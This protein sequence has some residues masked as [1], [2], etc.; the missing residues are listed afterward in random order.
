MKS[1][2]H[3]GG[4]LNV[5]N[6]VYYSDT[7]P[8]YKVAKPNAYGGV[9]AWCAVTWNGLIGP[10]FPEGKINAEVY[11][12]MLENEF[13]PELRK[14]VDPRSTWFQQ[15]GARA[16]TAQTTQQYLNGVFG[17][18]W[19]GK[20]SDHVWPAGSPDLTV[21]DYWLWNRLL[22]DTNQTP[23]RTKEQMKSAIEKACRGV[24][25]QECQDA[26]SGF[27]RRL[28]ECVEKRGEQVRKD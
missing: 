27:Q 20:G 21:C 13:L 25:V 16:H 8:N 1:F 19:I 11:Q 24:T 14:R 18:H 15:D 23:N 17:K 3:L 10:F 2:F 12:E 4:E 6:M 26:I 22:G 28:E 7:N 9:M 5:H